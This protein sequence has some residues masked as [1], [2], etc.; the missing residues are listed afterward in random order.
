MMVDQ[1]VLQR[2]LVEDEKLIA[3]VLRGGGDENVDEIWDGQ[4][5]LI[6]NDLSF[7]VKGDV[8]KSGHI[9]RP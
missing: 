9:E 1:H 7:A 6:P 2:S 4:R 8:H 3:L 5:F